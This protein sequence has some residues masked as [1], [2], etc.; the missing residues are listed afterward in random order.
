MTHIFIPNKNLLVPAKDQ[1]LGMAQQIE[2]MIRMVCHKVDAHGDIVHSRE[3]AHFPNLITDF[4]LNR[5]GSSS[6][7]AAYCQVGSGTTP[8]TFGDTALV[9][10]VASSNTEDSSNRS[11][12][13][14]V[15]PPRFS[16]HVS[17]RRFAAG[18]AAGTLSEVGFGAASTGQLWNRA[19]IR[20]GSGNPTTITVLSDE[21]LDVYLETRLYIPTGD[22]APLVLNLGGVNYTFVRR[23]IRNA[24]QRTIG[25]SAEGWGLYNIPS[26]PPIPL[27]GGGTGA[28]TGSSRGSSAYNG[29]IT[30]EN[31]IEPGGT[32]S[33]AAATNAS[34][35]NNSL[36]RDGTLTWDITR[37]NLA[38]GITAI[39]VTTQMSAWQYS[40]SPAIPKTS[41]Q[42]LTLNVRQSWNRR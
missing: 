18:V 22:S 21:I 17:M 35:V 31:G 24:V 15:G 5:L 20:D 9:A 8:P 25:G 19:L 11:Q 28:G 34:Y 7:S 26:G 2:Q 32:P 23:V 27:L 16:S 38:G 14:V 3:V 1:E 4:G 6:G 39:T 10:L 40:V 41:S 33:G 12:Q 29:A 30:T 37:G 42:T 13:I 36:Q